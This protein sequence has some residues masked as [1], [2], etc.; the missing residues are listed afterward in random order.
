[1]S[2]FMRNEIKDELNRI[3]MEES[4]HILYAC[5]SGS[6]A[7]GFE[8]KDSDYDIRF[9]YLRPV[10]WYLSIQKRRDVIERPISGA[11]DL[12]GWDLPKALGLFYKSN[13][14]LLEWLQSPI[15]YCENGPAASRLR[16]LMTDYYDPNACLY[17]Y[18]HMAENNNRHYLQKETVW[19]KKYLYVLRPILACLW[20]EAG[21]GVVPM[22]FAIL[23]D[24]LIPPGSLKNAIDEL[25]RMKKAGLELDQGP[26]ISVISDFLD[27]QLSRLFV[28]RNK[29]P[30]KKDVARLDDL[31]R[32]QVVETYGN[33]IDCAE[34]GPFE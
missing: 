16:N 26:R 14:P 3:E 15:V 32:V 9:I 4:V 8:S 2:D 31:F 28:Q 17:S 33:A 19:V 1:M 5:E 6:R 21:L 13:P 34:R 22:E 23:V 27:E 30:V 11:L 20:I 7:W 12:V 25:V 18:L 24:R 29:S 10:A